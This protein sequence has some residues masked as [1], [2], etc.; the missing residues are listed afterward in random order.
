MGYSIGIG[1]GSFAGTL[2]GWGY[3]VSTTDINGN[4]RPNPEGSNPDIGSSENYLGSP[5]LSPDIT[6]SGIIMSSEDSSPLSGASIIVVEENNIYNTQ[7]SS[8]SSGYYSIDVISGFNY[9][10]NVS[11]FNYQEQSQ[12]IFINDSSNYMD[13]Y[14]DVDQTVQDALVEGTVTDWYADTPLS[15]ATVLF[16]Y[17][18]NSGDIETIE[19]ATDNSG[20]FMV[21]VPGEKDYDLF[22]YADGYWVEHDAFYLGS[23]DGQVLSIGIAPMASAARLYGTVRDLETEA[24]GAIPMLST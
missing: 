7:S 23:G 14:L 6:L 21:Q 16:A 3:S 2:G 11:L 17:S 20:Y 4:I 22:I 8:D 24:I 1:D 12:Y 19:A 13:I 18:G 15:A 10:V 5:L 9:Y